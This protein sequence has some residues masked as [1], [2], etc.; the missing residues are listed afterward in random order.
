MSEQWDIENWEWRFANLYFV[1]DAETGQPILLQPRI[2]QKA[3]L[4]AIYRSKWRNLL[5][6]KARQLGIS[7]IID[8]IILDQILFSGGTTAAIIDLTQGDATKKLK[9]KIAFA[10]ERLPR[11][12][13]EAYEIVDDSNITFSIRLKGATD[14]ALSQ[15]EAGMHARGDTYQ[16]MHV[17]EWG[18]IAFTDQQRSEEIMTGALPAAKH[19]LKLIETTWKGGKGGHLWNIT[20]AAMETRP[21]DMTKEDFHLFFFAWFNDPSYVLEGNYDQIPLEVNQY[22]DKIEAEVNTTFTRQQRLWYFK[23]AWAKGI[24]RFQEYPSTLAEAFRSPI[25]GAIYAEYIDQL[26]TQGAICPFQVDGTALVHTAWDLGSPINTVVW[27]FQ[28]IAQEIRIIDCDS[29]MDITSVDRVAHMYR[30]GYPLGWHYLPHDALAT[31]KSGKTFAAEL[32]GIGLQNVRVVPQA[33]DVWI[34]INQL[35]EIFPRLMFRIPHC[36]KGL[37]ALTCYRTKR[38]TSTGIAVDIPV[39]DFASH[40][41]D[42]MR[43]L[44]EAEM[45]GMI[46][47]IGPRPS[48]LKPIVKSGVRDLQSQPRRPPDP[49]ESMVQIQAQTEAEGHLLMMSEPVI[50]KSID[51]KWVIDY[52]NGKYRDGLSDDEALC[53]WCGIEIDPLPPE[54]GESPCPKEL[55]SPPSLR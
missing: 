30:K 6:I 23:V 3:V 22:L 45:H 26:R 33:I 39:H 44:A 34:G 35:R 50:Y 17:S 40:Y 53:L 38:E 12:I 47:S 54:G 31:Q 27:F 7:T 14:D 46:H 10:F 2:E 37:D 41:A 49:V 15:V 25:E 20:K 18:K 21:A 48:H 43:T 42:G 8:L 11:P 13:R 5:I 24:F 32:K 51:G 55:Q 52:G 36:E 9:G 29:D 28:V 16:V 4:E 19:G 1:D